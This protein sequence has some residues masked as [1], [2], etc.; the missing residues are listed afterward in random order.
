[1][2]ASSGFARRLSRMT[3]RAMFAMLSPVRVWRARIYPF[4]HG[5]RARYDERTLIAA[6]AL[7]AMGVPHAEGGHRR[8]GVHRRDRGPDRLLV[9][10]HRRPGGVLFSAP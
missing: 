3:V 6:H 7:P 2:I 5:R 9:D 10:R 4:G 8:S 1:M